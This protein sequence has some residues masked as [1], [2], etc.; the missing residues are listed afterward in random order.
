MADNQIEK[1]QARC[2]PYLVRLRMLA[3]GEAEAVLSRRVI[4]EIAQATD[5]IVAE[6][7]A[8]GNDAR[9]ASQASPGWSSPGHP[10]AG[11]FLRVRLNRLAAAAEDAIAAA[12]AANFADMRSHLRRFD[13]L[14][15][16]IWTVLHSVYGSNP[17]RP[18]R[19]SAV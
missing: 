12:R 1:H 14:T 16:A 4:V 7:E 18:A 19:P 5:A 9:A 17:R 3:H 11:P 10:A 8:A 15:T 2:Q 6:A 13:T